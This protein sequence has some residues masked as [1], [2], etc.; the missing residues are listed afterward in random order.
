MI[1]TIMND[2]TT[3][4]TFALPTEDSD[5]IERL[6]VALASSGHVL[7]RSE[8][9]RLGLLA[10]EFVADENQASYLVKKLHRRKPGR[11]PQKKA[12]T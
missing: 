9:V 8:V 12:K 1:C 6:Q 2:A 10:L 7:N 5:R 11:R 3:R 4:P